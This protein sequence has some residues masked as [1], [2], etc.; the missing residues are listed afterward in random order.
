MTT[1]LAADWP[2]GPA[3]RGMS[4][5]AAGSVGGNVF[6]GAL[7]LLLALGFFV[8]SVRLFFRVRESDR[9]PGTE[10]VVTSADIEHEPRRPLGMEFFPRITFEYEVE[11]RRYTGRRWRRGATGFQHQEDAK[12]VLARYPVGARVTVYYSPADP[13]RSLL[14]RGLAGRA[15]VWYNVILGVVAL[16][17]GIWMVTS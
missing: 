2:L 14:E 1:S 15:V 8:Q 10:G 17:L 16:L 12:Q 5:L 13:E 9:W 6:V 7:T 4:F 11:G 3:E